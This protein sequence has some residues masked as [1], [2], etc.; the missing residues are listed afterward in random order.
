[1]AGALEVLISG[2]DTYK[3]FLGSSSPEGLQNGSESSWAY[4]HALG[5]LPADLCTLTSMS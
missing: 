2:K 3:D 5:G 1:M 4:V